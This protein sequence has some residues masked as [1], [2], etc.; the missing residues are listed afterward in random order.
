MSE[1]LSKKWLALINP[2]SGGGKVKKRWTKVVKN[3]FDAMGL[4]YT[5]Y[6]TTAPVDAI[7]KI[8]SE[9]DNYDGFI[10]I[11]GDGTVNE[12]L[13]GII[14]GT[15]E[16]NKV[17]NKIFA[18]V[19]C[20]TGNDIS[21]AMGLPHKDMKEACKAFTSGVLKRIDAGKATGENFKGEK[22]NRYFCGVLSTGFDAEVAF[23]T[24]S[25]TKWLPGTMNY[26]KSLLTSLLW[27]K[28]R[29]YI[30]KTPETTFE[31]NGILLAVG[32]GQY[33]GGGM[34][35]CP[36]AKIDDG[37][38]DIVFLKKVSRLTMLRVFPKVYDGK[39]LSHKAVFEYESASITISNTIDTYWQV[40]GETIG[41]TPVDITTVKDA[42]QILTFPDP[43]E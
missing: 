33:Y 17:N 23:K 12:V 32:L 37:L 34:M 25:G 39:H 1:I 41:F 26:V 4:Q 30:V 20:G 35:V 13:N 9:I 6:Y 38:F 42:L 11:G 8:E 16:K 7:T 31:E 21:H 2:A 24:N 18:T 43:A 36:N 40:D 15:L 10:A 5:E 28:T 3:E 14:H 19:P 22:V 27:M 29:G